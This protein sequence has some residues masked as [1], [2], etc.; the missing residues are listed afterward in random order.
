MDGLSAEDP[1]RQIANVQPDRMIVRRRP[2]DGFV[3]TGV[4]TPGS[5]RREIRERRKR[6]VGDLERMF[7]S[8]E[9]D[10]ILAELERSASTGSESAGTTVSI[11]IAISTNGMHSAPVLAFPR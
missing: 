1:T 6:I 5:L 8:T 4:M 3:V 7:Q 10:R 11:R 2:S 9:A